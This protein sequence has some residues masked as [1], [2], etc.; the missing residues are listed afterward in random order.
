[1]KIVSVGE[2]LW[3][4]FPDSERLGGAPFNFAVHAHRLGNEVIFV[5]AVGDDE[6]GER[7]LARVK[8]LGLSTEFVRRV[9]GQPTGTV[10]V[11]FDS[12]GEP[13]FTIHRPAAYDFLELPRMDADWIYYGTLAH[14]STFDRSLWSRLRASPIASRFYDMNL[15]RD[16][17]T[18]ALVEDLMRTANVAKLN[19]EELRFT[20]R[21]LEQLR[22]QF[23]WQACC[24]TRGDRGCA[25]LIGKDYAEVPAYPV[26]VID[27]VGAG[28]AF[29]AA[30]LHGLDQGWPA[31]KIGEFANHLGAFVASRPGAIP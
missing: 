2:I 6:R 8:E 17:F 12:A 21:T 24:V 28:D 19:E 20:G 29:A 31:A 14:H 25:I 13:D 26:K 15:R 1:M 5:S 10:A 9:P 4:I 23:G 22:D 3:D 27:S 16:S 11:H 30:F 7:A 18:P